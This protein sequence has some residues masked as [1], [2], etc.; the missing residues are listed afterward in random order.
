MPRK[1]RHLLV[2]WEMTRLPFSHLLDLGLGGACFFRRSSR[3]GLTPRQLVRVPGAQRTTL[4]ILP[5]NTDHTPQSEASLVWLSQDDDVYWRPEG[6][7]GLLSGRNPATPLAL[8][9]RAL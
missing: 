7:L 2:Q 1:L 6:L 9:F 8:G 3:H 4:N 5:R